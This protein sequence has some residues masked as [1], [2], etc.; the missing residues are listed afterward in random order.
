MAGGASWCVYVL[1]CADGSYYVG[2]TSRLEQRLAEHQ[3]GRGARYTQTRRPI[4][5][6]CSFGCESRSA[7]QRMESR[8]KRLRHNQKAKLAREGLQSSGLQSG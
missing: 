2:S 7:A 3:A 1:E 5:L 6:A 4:S 8:L